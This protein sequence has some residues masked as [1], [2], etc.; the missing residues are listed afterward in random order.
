MMSLRSPFPWRT[1]RRSVVTCA[2]KQRDSDGRTVFQVHPPRNEVGVLDVADA[3]QA[4]V[5]M[6]PKQQKEYLYSQGIDYDRVMTY[7]IDVIKLNKMLKMEKLDD[8][9]T[10]QNRSKS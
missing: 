3:L 7:Y 6:T 2:N 4:A 9:G 10:K 8:V 1:H 5:R